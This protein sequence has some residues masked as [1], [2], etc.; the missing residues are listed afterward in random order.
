[1]NM[2]NN[3]SSVELMEQISKNI[4]EY[5]TERKFTQEQLAEK[6]NLSISFISRLERNALDNISI[7][8]L[9]QISKALNVSITNLIELQ[10]KNNKDIPNNLLMLN[11]YLLTLNDNETN[12]ISSN[13]L[14]LIKSIKNNHIKPL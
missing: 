14:N 10:N 12:I 6:S 2:T 7:L 3:I 11:N 9:N 5:R 8:K 1:M 13:I 4:K